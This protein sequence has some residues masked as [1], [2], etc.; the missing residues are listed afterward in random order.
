MTS[1]I[2]RLGIAFA[3]VVALIGAVGLVGAEM[4]S[5]TTG[6]DAGDSQIADM[7]DHMPGEMTD[8]MGGTEHMSGDMANHMDGDMADRMDGNVMQDH[9]GT[10]DHGGHHDGEHGHC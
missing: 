6:D 7:G 10:H 4:H 2:L 9:M 5:N 1:R 3:V 8:R